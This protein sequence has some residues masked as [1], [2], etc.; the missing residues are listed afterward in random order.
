MLKTLNVKTRVQ[1]ALAAIPGTRQFRRRI[2]KLMVKDA[3][4]GL[5]KFVSLQ[6]LDASTKQNLQRRIRRYENRL[7][8]VEVGFLQR[9][10]SML[11]VAIGSVW[12]ILAVWGP[13]LTIS[14]FKLRPSA[15]DVVSSS[16]WG[17]VLSM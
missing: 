3:R 2:R 7:A 9:S 17:F 16:M 10:L 13:Y 5:Q 8:V 6:T 11:W 12:L 15:L 4:E 14:W 1:G